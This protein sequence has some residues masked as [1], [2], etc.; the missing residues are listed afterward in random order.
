MNGGNV[1]SLGKVSGYCSKI[2]KVLIGKI[3]Q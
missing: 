1:T 2:V 3:V